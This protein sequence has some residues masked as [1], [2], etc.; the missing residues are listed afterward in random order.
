MIHFE[1]LASESRAIICISVILMSGFL[2]TRITKK[3]SLPN[4]TA[5][6][7]TGILLGPYAFNVIP[8]SF[9]KGTGFLPDIALSFIAFS[10]GEHFK[11]EALKRSGVKTLII[12]VFETASAFVFVFIL[13]RFILRLDLPFSLVLS[14]L[15]T[16]TAP[17]STM[18]TIRQTKA[19][20]DF[21]ETLLQVV[22]LDDVIA[23]LMFSAA[24]AVCEAFSNNGSIQV[25][26]IVLPI[27]ENIIAVILGALFGLLLTFFINEKRTHDNRLIISLSVI[28]GFCG[29]CTIFDIS[30]LLGC[31]AMSTVY[32]NLGGDEKLFKQ[33]NYFSPPILLMFFVRS[34]INFD[35][36]ALFDNSNAIGDCSLFLIGVLYFIVR[37]ISKYAGA[38]LGCKITGKP[39]IVCKYL[40][41][42]LFP[43]AGVAIGLAALGARIIGGSS[44]LALNTVIMTS[45]ILYELVGPVAAKTALQLS[46][47]FPG[48][49]PTLNQR[50]EFVSI[51]NRENEEAFNEAIRESEEDD[52]K[53]AK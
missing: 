38:F 53:Q 30:P 24:V 41:F 48:S 3:L 36:D 33:L 23:L 8:S 16:A 32:I 49:G 21:V 45:S 40:G 22:A 34:G 25:M 4:V 44:G 51:Q 9:V 10:T 52:G 14:A 7:V 28:F 43:Q 26:E 11:L 15:A 50:D 19:S 13:S 37:I 12:T 20:G 18:M 5:Y 27:I 6:I 46:G 31:M 2:M 42:A 1:T 29:I 35:L 39:H 17:A 47:S